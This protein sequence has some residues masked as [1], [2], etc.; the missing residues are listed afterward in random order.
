MN[1]QDIIDE[2]PTGEIWNKDRFMAT[3]YPEVFKQRQAELNLSL[4]VGR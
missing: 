4:V 1:A 3:F 2:T